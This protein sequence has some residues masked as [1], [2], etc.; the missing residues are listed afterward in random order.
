MVRRRIFQSKP[1][2]AHPV[3]NPTDQPLPA[4]KGATG[5]PPGR[6]RRPFWLLRGGSLLLLVLAF[7]YFVWPTP[8]EYRYE[9][10]Y[11]QFFEIRVHRLTG[12][13]AIGANVAGQSW[14]HALRNPFA[15]RVRWDPVDSP[16]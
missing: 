15:C 8:Y 16:R 4:V 9:Q 6:R 10:V 2:M 12:Q 1:G 3:G 13:V 11:N 14:Q 7:A 5:R